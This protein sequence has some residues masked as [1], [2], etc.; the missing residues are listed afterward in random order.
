MHSRRTL[1]LCILIFVLVA[2]AATPLLGQA[3][4]IITITGPGW[5]SRAFTPEVF[6]P[7]EAQHPG[8]KVVVADAGQDYYYPS[9]AANID[10]HLN[11]AEKYATYA[12]VLYVDHRMASIEATRAGY[13]VNLAPYVN[14]DPTFDT[15]D[16]FPKIWQSALWDDGIWYIPASAYVSLLTY[17]ANAFDQANLAYPNENWTFENFAEAA[18][19]LTT[20]KADGSVDV[21]GFQLYNPALYFYG[22]SGQPLY[23]PG[24]SPSVPK[25]DQ[26]DLPAFVEQWIALDKDI[27]TDGQYDYDA[28]SFQ[29]GAPWYTNPTSGDRRWESALMPGGISSLS[30]EGF[31]V[32]GGTL[33]PE[34]SYA[35]ANFVSTNPEI[36]DA[37]GGDTPARRSM[38]IP[39]NGRASAYQAVLDQALENAVPTSELRFADYME[40]AINKQSADSVQSDI[41]AALQEAQLNALNALEVAAGRR[42]STVIYVTT[43]VPTPSFSAGQIVLRF[44]LGSDLS[45]TRETWNQIKTD[46]LAANPAVGNV[47][48]ITDFFDEKVKDTLDCYFMPYNE[49]PALQLENYLS[50]DPLMNADPN[51][52]QNDFIGTALE[53][54][55]R[56]GQTWAYPITV[57]PAVMWYDPNLFNQAGLPSPEQGWT[58]DA[59]RDALQTLKSLQAKETDP[60]FVSG[61]YG[62]TY[63]LMLIAAFGGIPYDYRTSPPTINF[64][65]PTVIDAIRQTL[66]L[67]KEGYIGYSSLFNNLVFNAVSEASITDDVLS[68]PNWRLQERTNPDSELVPLHLANYPQGS[69]YTPVAFSVG[70][71]YIKNTSQSPD[72][73][74]QWISEIAKRPDIL[75]GMPARIS[76]VNDP[77][78]TTAL[79][80]EVAGIYQDFLDTFQNPNTLTFP[81]PYGGPDFNLS[82]YVEPLWL[83]RAFD[84]YVLEDADLETE[85]AAAESAVTAYRECASVIPITVL[86][87]QSSEEEATAYY[88]QFADCAVLVDPTMKEQF[89]Y[90]YAS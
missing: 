31:A 67:A 48:L 52:D 41:P 55:K 29:S 6:A 69:Q 61:T 77:L 60:V 30:I 32:S 81:S 54:V 59:F 82:N 35:L 89:S 17:D 46:F 36:I 73:C 65:D 79:G 34:L 22:L 27:S 3:E 47:D 74:Y 53:Q 19:A 4:T 76:Q 72:A 18:R 1:L 66:D 78:L 58:I 90:L 16:F 86:T 39:N 37:F 9:A 11:G 43:P 40:V 84:R 12:D 8:V 15:S 23:D 68:I 7:F 87:T 50:L 83:N 2:T 45:S 71:A 13:F 14:S 62:N 64:T 70:T 24:I 33:N 26:P 38:V 56:D 42:S 63:L 51:F 49:V 5:V 85:L 28:V 20:Y 21:P 44:G 75:G 57:Q 25:F 88:K 80:D 10:Q